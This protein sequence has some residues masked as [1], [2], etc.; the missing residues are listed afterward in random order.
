[1]SVQA[2]KRR[3]ISVVLAHG[4]IETFDS[5]ISL[6]GSESP[7]GAEHRWCREH[8]DECRHDKDE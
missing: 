5:N 1:M 3:A 7:D 6:P 2:T 4:Q 8:Q